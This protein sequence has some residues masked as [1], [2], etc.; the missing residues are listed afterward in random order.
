MRSCVDCR[1]FL[2]MPLYAR[3]Q[4]YLGEVINPEGERWEIQFKGG[5]Y[6]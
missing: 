2:M 1:A 3:V 5:K 4:M 6:N